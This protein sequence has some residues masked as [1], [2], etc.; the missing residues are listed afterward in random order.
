MNIET[1]IYNTF[2]AEI[3]ETYRYMSPTPGTGSYVVLDMV[4]D[5]TT[6]NKD[7][8]MSPH[9]G[10]RIR[11]QAKIYSSNADTARTMVHTCQT[12]IRTTIDEIADNIKWTYA[13][14]ASTTGGYTP[15][16]KRFY[17]IIDFIVYYKLLS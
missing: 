13:E 8:A 16:D 7:I 9:P 14:D 2:K 4:S 3:S 6:T 12:L 17:Y 10:A 11:M 5:I 1:L 15:V